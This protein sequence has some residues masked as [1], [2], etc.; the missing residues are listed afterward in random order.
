MIYE[1][2]K[3][4]LIQ[5]KIEIFLVCKLHRNTDNISLTFKEMEKSTV[6]TKELFET[7]S[8]YIGTVQTIGGWVRSIRVQ[9]K[10]GSLGFVKMYDGQCAVD[11]QVVMNA[12]VYPDFKDMFPKIHTGTAVS[13]TGTIVESIGKEQKSEM[14]VTSVRIHGEIADPATYPIAK[15]AISPETLRNEYLELSFRTQLRACIMRV[16]STVQ[17]ALHEFFRQRKFVLTHPA[18]LTE[19]ECESGA[20]PFTVC[21]TKP[22]GTLDAMSFF[23][24]KVYLTVSSQLNLEAIC[25]AIGCQFK[26]GYGGVW[27][28][29][30]AFR[31]EPSTGR[32]HLAEIHMPEWEV[33]LCDLDDNMKIAEDLVKFIIATVLSESIEDMKLFDKTD[34]GIISRLQK[35]HDTPFVRSSHKECVKLMLADVEAGKVKFQVMPAYDQDM[36][37]EHERYITETLYGGLPVFV[38]WYP[39]KI[40][41]FYMPLR[42]TDKEVVRVDGY[43]MVF[44]YVGEVVGGSQRETDYET[45]LSRMV[46]KGV[47]PEKLKFYTNLRKYG[48]CPHGGAGLG[49]DRL[50]LVL[51]GQDNIRDVVPFPRS[52]GKCET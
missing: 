12:D 8:E 10:S 45:L 2:V 49:L 47:D 32:L 27:C 41:A 30:T 28:N 42:D 9:G 20:N 22:D 5:G 35:Y 25:Q 21:T 51:T 19:N 11:Y 31:A 23:G 13:F 6:S 43:D 33:A 1:N 34:S 46:E 37:K 14:Q 7:P 44:P 17:Y 18:L 50:M 40:K 29:T 24:K 16:S 36:E 39:E 4:V 15:K 38:R 3:R 48:T 26:P 52:Y